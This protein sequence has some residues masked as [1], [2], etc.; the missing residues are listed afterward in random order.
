MLKIYV[1]STFIDLE[2]YRRMVNIVLRRLGH[3]DIAME[4][5]VAEDVRP[6]DKCL[7]DVSNANLYIGIFAWR[8]GWIPDA[9]NSD[10]L[11]ITE[12]E[13]RQAVASKKPCLIFMLSEKAP[14]PRMYIDKDTTRIDTFR[15]ELAKTHLTGPHFSSPD[16]LGRLVAEAL[17]KLGKTDNASP[18]FHNLPQP[19]YEQ[20]VMRAKY[21]KEVMEGLK[22]RY[23]VITIEGFAGVGKTSL[24]I[25]TGYIVLGL[26]KSAIPDPPKFTYVVWISAV[27]KPEQKEW[28]S[29]VV[30]EVLST[31]SNNS[32]ATPTPLNVREMRLVNELLQRNKVLIIIDNFETMPDPRLKKWMESV[33]SPSKVLL[34]SR[35]QLWQKAYPIR[36]K[37]LAKNEATRFISQEA[38]AKG[39]TWDPKLLSLSDITGGNPQAIVLALGLMAGGRL[40]LNEIRN[41][42]HLSTPKSIREVFNSLYSW[43][44]SQITGQARCIL[45]TLPLFSAGNSLAQKTANRTTGIR[46]LAVC[47]V[48]GLQEFEF[49]CALQQLVQYGLLEVDGK[50][51]NIIVHPMTRE[52]VSA[53]LAEAPAFHEEARNRFSNYYFEYVSNNIKRTTPC[54]RYWNVLVNDNMLAIDIE[55]SNINEV[56]KWTSSTNPNGIFYDLLLLL[57]HYMDSRFLNQERIAYVKQAIEVAHTRACLEDEALLRLDALGWTYVEEDRLDDAY[58]E[59]LQGFNI[60]SQLPETNQTKRDLLALGLAWQARVMAEKDE[61]ATA[62]KLVKEALSIP[63]SAWIQTRVYMVAGDIE[64][65]SDNSEKALHY[66]QLAAGKIDYGEEGHGYQLEPR[67]GLAYLGIENGLQEAKRRFEILRAQDRIAIGRLYG[68]YGLALVAYKEKNKPKAVKMMQGIIQELSP[69]T[70][71]NLLQKLIYKLFR[72]LEDDEKTLAELCDSAMDNVELE[73]LSINR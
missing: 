23:P 32:S 22:T 9:G 26:A 72:D 17:N 51:G 55:W 1:S 59:I 60:A 33:P 13:Y 25:E 64:F 57:V 65:K 29:E 56:L 3:E 18:I 45:L 36:V 8:Y 21:M 40:S 46:R 16:E 66:Y 11:S 54:E 50:E 70:K 52:H 69:K 49:D 68:E 71:S 44:W 15:E 41:H 53:K 48:S 5:Y 37:G 10:G 20:F 24:A 38:K 62:E 58:A 31:V 14:W 6:L 61:P 43:S 42:I 12:L 63:C 4:Y 73:D 67:I 35:V 2:D 19:N 28:L 34:T 7:L 30:N 27:D 39:I 47:K